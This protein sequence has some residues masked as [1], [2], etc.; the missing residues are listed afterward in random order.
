MKNF[1]LALS[2]EEA[3]SE[4]KI[5]DALRKQL[6][7]VF[8]DTLRYSILKRSIDARSREV[9]VRLIVAAAINEE[10]PEKKFEQRQLK[11][12]SN[13]K[14]VVI[15][16]C[17]PAGMFAAIR[18]IELGYKPIIIERGKNVKDR[19]RDIAALNRKGIVDPDSNYC[20]GEGG[21]GTYSDGKLYTRSGK[22]GS[23]KKILETLIQF[24]AKEAIAIDAHPHIGTNKLPAIIENIRNCILECGGEILFGT[25]FTS[26][27]LNGNKIKGVRT[28]T[29]MLS[30]ADTFIPCETVILA[31]GHSAR[32][33]YEYFYHNNF[34]LEA[35]PFALGVR[36][37]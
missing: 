22:R 10:L 1:E 12:I 32:D 35:K 16:G 11:N 18:L 8:S 36:I 19:R 24:G 33:V 34:I 31:T 9:K 28:K 27:E 13:A 7:L 6:G 4:K 29:V 2:P 15:I 25:R 5:S 30:E 37:E 20:F 14:P 3:A 21:A 17:G 23:I 26:F